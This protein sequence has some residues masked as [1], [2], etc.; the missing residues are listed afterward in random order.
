MTTRE[1]I[2]QELEAVPDGALDELFQVIQRLKEAPRKRSIMARL[3][4]IKIEASA[5]LARA[6]MRDD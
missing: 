6:L 4:E 5:D 2:Q 1:R 3:R